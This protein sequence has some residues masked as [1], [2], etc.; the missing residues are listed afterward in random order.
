MRF[1]CAIFTGRIS[2]QAFVFDRHVGEAPGHTGVHVV[3]RL[4]LTTSASSSLVGSERRRNPCGTSCD[5]L[6]AEVPLQLRDDAGGARLVDADA[7]DPELH[8]ELVDDELHDRV[9]VDEAARRRRDEASL[10]FQSGYGILSSWARRCS[11]FSGIQKN[12]STSTAQLIVGRS[13]A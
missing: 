11:V 3:V 5:E 9:V 7:A 4:P 2:R 1:R 10:R 12:G 13:A 6:V 8:G